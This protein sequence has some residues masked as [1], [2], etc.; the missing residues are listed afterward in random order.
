MQSLTEQPCSFSRT[1]NWRLCPLFLLAVLGTSAC[2]YAK[3]RVSG[4]PSCCAVQTLVVM[5]FL[6]ANGSERCIDELRENMYQI[7][8]L[9]VMNK[10]DNE[11]NNN[12]NNNSDT[13]Y[14]IIDR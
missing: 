2:L 6:V 9:F 1:P 10:N 8:V 14:S 12:N 5:E 4:A 7:Q 11:Y 13:S 3:P